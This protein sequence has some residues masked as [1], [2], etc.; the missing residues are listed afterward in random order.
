[1]IRVVVLACAL[2]AAFGL[3]PHAGHPWLDLAWRSLLLTALY[4]PAVHVLQVAP[5]LGAQVAK[6]Y[7]R[8]RGIIMGR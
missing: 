4:W 5:E 7:K 2:A 6:L 3:L 8:S 1:S